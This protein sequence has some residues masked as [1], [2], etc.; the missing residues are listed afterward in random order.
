MAR[1]RPADARR[2]RARRARSSPRLQVL[3]DTPLHGQSVREPLGGPDTP[4]AL[5]IHTNVTAETATK[6]ILSSA[7]DGVDLSY[8]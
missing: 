2:V 8:V 7:D 6:R 1:L 4:R 3:H 5:Y